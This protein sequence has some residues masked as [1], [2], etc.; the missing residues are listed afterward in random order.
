M[1]IYMHHGWKC[2]CGRLFGTVYEWGHHAAFCP[3]ALAVDF[4]GT[5]CTIDECESFDV[6]PTPSDPQRIDILELAVRV[7][8]D[9]IVG[10]YAAPAYVRHRFIENMFSVRGEGPHNLH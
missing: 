7:F 9:T 2:E 5:H 8:A 3:E 1:D 4:E 10:T 6:V